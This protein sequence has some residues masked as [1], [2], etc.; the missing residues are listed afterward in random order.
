MI[1][2]LGGGSCFLA[3]VTWVLEDVAKGKYIYPAEEITANGVYCD[4]VWCAVEN[5]KTQ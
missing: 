5:L 4:N 2:S 3:L 1:S